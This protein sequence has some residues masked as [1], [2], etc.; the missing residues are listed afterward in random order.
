M[1]LNTQMSTCP[2]VLGFSEIKFSCLDIQY[3]NLAKEGAWDK[4]C[5]TLTLP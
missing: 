5:A 2:S 4:E 1:R 3:L